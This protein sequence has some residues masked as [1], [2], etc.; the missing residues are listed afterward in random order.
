MTQKIDLLTHP[1]KEQRERMYQLSIQAAKLDFKEEEILKNFE[2]NF[3]KL[4]NDLKEHSENE[5]W[6]ILPLLQAK[7]PEEV[8]IFE[9]EHPSIEEMLNN[10][11]KKLEEIK[12][13]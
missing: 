4:I 6:F 7:S 13:S 1:H 9:K 3:H 12:Q 10:L 5:E 11:L 2:K 8:S